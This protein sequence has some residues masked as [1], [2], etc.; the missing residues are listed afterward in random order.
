MNL[1]ACSGRAA[2]S[3]GSSCLEAARGA[4]VAKT[5]ELARKNVALMEATAEK[6]V[7]AKAVAEKSLELKEVESKLKKAVEEKEEAD[8]ARSMAVEE[9][10]RAEKLAEN[11]MAARAGIATPKEKEVTQALEEK[12]RAEIEKKQAL[13]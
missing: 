6:E 7:C 3:D 1:S 11:A 10:L 5:A 9:K 13:V 8:N 4:P 2:A 12:I